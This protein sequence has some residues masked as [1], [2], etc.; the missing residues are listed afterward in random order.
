MRS[1]IFPPI[2]MALM[3]SVSG[4]AA[5]GGPDTSTSSTPTDS[6]TPS[7]SSTTAEAE[8]SSGDGVDTGLSTEAEATVIFGVLGALAGGLIGGNAQSALIGG[9]VGALGGLAAGT[10]VA[11]QQD[12][13]AAEEQTLD[14]QIAAMDSWNS[15]LETFNTAMRERIGVMNREIAAM[16]TDYRNGQRDVARAT[17]MNSDIE[18]QLA[19][20]NGT[21]ADTNEE[22]ATQRKIY[23][24][25]R[26]TGSATDQELQAYQAQ[27]TEMESYKSELDRQADDLIENQ[28]TVVS[29]LG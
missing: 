22:L 16:E 21:L 19:A 2:A 13:Y 6:S 4:C 11:N 15:E 3:L 10:A 14:Q 29:F 25:L 27:I 1:M 24:G 28:V 23:D 9:G 12:A 5:T 7:D 20:V 18:R 17:K 26:E 8:E